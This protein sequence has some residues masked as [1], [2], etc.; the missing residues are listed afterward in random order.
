MAYM[1]PRTKRLT[2]KKD[3]TRLALKGR[4]IFGPY[5]TLRIVETR[6]NETSRVGFITSVKM[7]KRAVDRN[8]TKR[9]LREAVRGLLAEIPPNV[10]LLFIAKPDA[11][12]VNYQ[13]LVVEIRRLVSKIPEALLHPPRPSSRGKKHVVRMTRSSK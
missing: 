2:K 1:L 7:M 10:N 3:F 4:S 11:R 5:A 6:P 9:R 13:K 8:R 12:D